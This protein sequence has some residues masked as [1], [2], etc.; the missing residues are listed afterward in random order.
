VGLS[1]TRDGGRQA[2][3]LRSTTKKRVG[4]DKENKAGNS[5]SCR[6]L[7]WE[8]LKELPKGIKRVSFGANS[9]RLTAHRT[10]L[11]G[12]AKKKIS[13]ER[14]LIFHVQIKAS[15]GRKKEKR[16]KSVNRISEGKKRN[17][18]ERVNGRRTK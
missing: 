8:K 11:K 1:D 17:K 3:P 18:K 15:K 16:L 5:K 4:S 9:S 14:K 12:E 7:R 13:T 6:Y 10:L 2:T